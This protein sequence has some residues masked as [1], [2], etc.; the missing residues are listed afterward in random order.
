M[1][2]R[3]LRRGSVHFC[4]FVLGIALVLTLTLP[5]ILLRLSVSFP[6][7]QAVS[8]FL[9]LALPLLAP[10]LSLLHVLTQHREH[11]SSSSKALRWSQTENAR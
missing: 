3:L 2:G 6:R 9:S 11:F 10:A 8:P 5:L 1:Q 7:P 4:A